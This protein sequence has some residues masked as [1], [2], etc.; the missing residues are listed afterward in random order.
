[1]I[2]NMKSGI[3]H[4]LLP[5]DEYKTLHVL[6]IFSEKTVILSG[7]ICKSEGREEITECDVIRAMQQFALPSSGF[8]QT[9][10]DPPDEIIHVKPVPVHELQVLW[11]AWKPCK[12]KDEL[13]WLVREKIEDLKKNIELN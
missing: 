10:D 2:P 11:D 4:S 1:M 8:W 9:M 3:G 12:N 13:G 6:K 7:N 5:E